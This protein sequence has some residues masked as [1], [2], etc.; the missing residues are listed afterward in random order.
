MYKSFYGLRSNPFNVNPDPRH[1]LLTRAAKETLASLS[2]GVQNRKGFI[3]LT[4]EVGTGKTTL[5]N[6]FLDWAQ[7]QRIST[8]FVFNPRLTV[9]EFLQYVLND[10]GIPHE[11]QNKGQ[12]LTTFNRWLLERHKSRTTAVLVIDEAQNL[13]EEMLEE[14]RLLTNLETATEKLL[15]IVLSGQPELEDILARPQLRQLRQRITLRCKTVPLTPEEVGQYI[16]KRLQVAGTIDPIFPE[17]AIAQIHRFS[18]G[19][20]RVVNMLCEQCLISGYVEQKSRIPI[21]TVLAA[22]KEMGLGESK[23]AAK[24]QMAVAAAAGSESQVMLEMLKMMA[25]LQEKLAGTNRKA[26]S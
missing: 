22:A 2:Y 24:Q 20:P 9:N 17:E 13:S 15:Q 16:T 8:A 4:G 25:T 3:L 19:I 10:F 1:L 18:E 26:E 14:I 23:H 6:R 7:M 11:G 12:M 21:E 5:I